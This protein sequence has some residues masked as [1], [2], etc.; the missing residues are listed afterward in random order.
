M[1]VIGSAVLHGTSE[2]IYHHCTDTVVFASTLSG[3]T[4]MGNTIAPMYNA[5]KDARPSL[6]WSIFTSSG[7]I[8]ISKSF[9][10]VYNSSNTAS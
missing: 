7:T 4:M 6:S 1:Y 5:E 10:L 3:N 2:I 9:Q 8:E